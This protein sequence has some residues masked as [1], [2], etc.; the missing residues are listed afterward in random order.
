MGLYDRQYYRE[1]SEAGGGIQGPRTVVGTIILINVIVFAIDTLWNSGPGPENHPLQAWLKLP[2]NV[3]SQPWE[4]W[5]LISY[6]F[7]HASIDSERFVWHILM[8][9]YCLWLFGRDVEQLYGAKEFLRIY[10]VLIAVA[11]A[12]WAL[13]ATGDRGGL[14]GASGGVAGIMV[15]F[16]LNFPH[17]KFILLPIPFQVPAWLLG[18]I[19]IGMDVIGAAGYR[20]ANVAYVAHLAGAAGAF[21]YYR[22]GIRLTQFSPS[23][24]FRSPF[25]SRPKLKVHNPK[26]RHA[27]LD[28]RADEILQKVHEHGADSITAEERKILDDYSR[29]MRQKHS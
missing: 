4:I 26:S 13:L 29:R 6:G 8:N 3:F 12:V 7:L 22:A 18:I 21:L 15:L 17:R 2:P 25:S 10:L 16:V 9:M 23:F 28:R 5:K 27:K 1:E 11:G 20:D 14:L 19:I 24:K